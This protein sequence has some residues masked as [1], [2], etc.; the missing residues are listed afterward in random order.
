MKWVKRK[1]KERRRYFLVRTCSSIVKR[2]N[3]TSVV[4]FLMIL[5][6]ESPKDF[7]SYLM[8]ALEIYF[9]G[10][11]PYPQRDNGILTPPHK[12]THIHVVQRRHNTAT[13]GHVKHLDWTSCLPSD[14]IWLH[15]QHKGSKKVLEDEHQS[16]SHFLIGCCWICSWSRNKLNSSRYSNFIDWRF[17]QNRIGRHLFWN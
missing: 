13:E 12:Q 10:Y 8:K 6:K 1:K 16:Y 5:S 14:W 7:S 2:R 15:R 3:A 4:P 17:H 11:P 9:P